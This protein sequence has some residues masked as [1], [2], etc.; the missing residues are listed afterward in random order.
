MGSARDSKFA[1]YEV[2]IIG[3]WCDEIR[4]AVFGC[5][6]PETPESQLF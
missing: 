4:S 5:E 6:A 1:V 2:E 3:D